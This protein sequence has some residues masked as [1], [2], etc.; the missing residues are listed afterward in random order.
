L[1]INEKSIIDETHSEAYFYTLFY[2]RRI[3]RAE[4]Y[5]NAVVFD[6]SQT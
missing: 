5:K 6:L 4:M 3:I 2:S 1:G